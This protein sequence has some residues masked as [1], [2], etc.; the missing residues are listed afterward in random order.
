MTSQE[1]LS[2][3]LKHY[4]QRISF[5]SYAQDK[6]SSNI[7]HVALFPRIRHLTLNLSISSTDRERGER[8]TWED[9]DF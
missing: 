4:L 1:K 8:Q 9:K 5:Q 2:I 7:F 6:K 3:Y